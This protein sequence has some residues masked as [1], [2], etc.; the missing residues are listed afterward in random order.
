MLRKLNQ[1]KIKV[2]E[3]ITHI[4]LIPNITLLSVF[5][6]QVEVNFFQSEK[7]QHGPKAD[8]VPLQ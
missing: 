5:W 2:R 8:C 7:N 3:G 1:G 4:S 6:F